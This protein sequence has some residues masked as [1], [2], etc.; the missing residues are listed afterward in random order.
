VRFFLISLLLFSV[1]AWAQNAVPAG[2][3][4]PAELS[5]SLDSAKSKPGQVITARIMQDVPLPA[6]RIPAG[7]RIIGHIVDVAPAKNGSG[8]EISLQFDAL[9][10]SHRSIPITTNLRAWAS[11]AEVEDAQ[12]PSTGPDRGTPWAWMTTNQIGG[13][14]VYGQDGPVTNGSSFVGRQAPGGVLVH[15]TTKPGS[16]CRSEVEGND[17]PQAL[18]LFSSDACGLYG[19]SGLEITHAGRTDPVGQI[20]IASKEGR[21]HIQGG[22]GFLLRVNAQ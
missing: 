18:W 14:V 3:V 10:F 21:L 17:S 7:A 22:S 12:I 5:A 11:M 1:A 2:T 8:M 4:L 19:F 9:R 13:E 15:L 16:M 6:G 20:R